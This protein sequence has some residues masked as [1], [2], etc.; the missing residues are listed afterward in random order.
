[1]HLVAAEYFV[2]SDLHYDVNYNADYAA[3]CGCNANPVKTRH[4][5]PKKADFAMPLG[6]PGCDSPLALI[7]SALHQM[8]IVDPDP[9]YILVT[10]DWIGHYVRDAYD[11]N[12][13]YNK[14]YNDAK[15]NKEF[16]TLADLI[17]TYFPSTQVIPVI[18][19]NDGLV[20][21]GFSSPAELEVM[22]KAWS[23]D[24]WMDSSALAQFLKGGYY[25]T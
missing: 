6:R 13:E 2:I 24:N 4:F 15:V 14:A 11:D 19:N 12:G 9:D 17:D 21:Y 7:E 22:G 1:M 3:S 20:D 23:R 16:T 8:K 10:G 25:T 18:G 5:T